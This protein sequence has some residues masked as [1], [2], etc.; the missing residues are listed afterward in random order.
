MN[1]ISFINRVP[2]KPPEVD[3]TNVRTYTE[4]YT[5]LYQRED[6]ILLIRINLNF[7][8]FAYL[9]V[10]SMSTELSSSVCISLH[11]RPKITMTTIAPR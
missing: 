1:P 8:I 9:K 7:S 6:S 2:V 4:S 3:S 5:S 10:Y 11:I